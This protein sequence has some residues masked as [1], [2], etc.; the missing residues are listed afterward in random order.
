AYRTRDGWIIVPTIGDD[1][2]RRWT[3]LVGREDLLTDPRCADDL[4]RGNHADLI[5]E[6]MSAWCAARTRDEAIAALERARIP[7]G[8]VYELEEVLPDAQ[9]GAGHLLK[10]FVYPGG[11]PPVPVENTPLRMSETPATVRRHAPLLGEHTDEI[12]AALDF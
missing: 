6:V 2:F 5:N 8:P 10:R 11:A 7:C 9:V 1:M 12:L 3:R 4:T